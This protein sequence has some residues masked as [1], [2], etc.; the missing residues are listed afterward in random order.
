MYCSITR[1]SSLLFLKEVAKIK[2]SKIIR[3]R[4]RPANQLHAAIRL[5]E[6]FRAAQFAVIIV[7]HAEP[8][9]AGIVD[10]QIIAAINTGQSPVD[11]KLVA[12]LA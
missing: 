4:L 12:V 1:R 10:K 5:Q 2:R 7:A 3:R 6:Q 9:R 8:V 11:G